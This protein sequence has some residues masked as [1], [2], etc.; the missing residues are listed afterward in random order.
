VN[1]LQRELA[2]ISERAWKAIDDEARRSL[3]HFLTG[4]SLFPFSGPRGYETNSVASGRTAGSL[5]MDGVRA[6]VLAVQP[7][8]EF[9][10]PFALSRD[11]IE[12]L[13]RDGDVDLAVVEDAARRAAAAEDRL[14]FNGLDGAGVDGCAS[15]S[16]HDPIKLADDADSYPRAVA[17]AVATLRGHGIGGPYGIALGQNDHLRVIESTE[18]GGYPVLQHLHLILDGPVVWAPIMDGAVVVSQ[19]GGGDF[20]I[21]SGIDFAVGYRAHDTDTVQLELRE[22]VT[23]RNQ[24][25][26]AAISIVH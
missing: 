9:R 2:P 21:V 16:P 8:I 15:A 12:V 4:R 1:S 24:S 6:S 26:E 3:E 17:Q 13:E 7:L 25:P 23:F 18:R 20:E 11:D 19:R 22:S 10:T 5:D 14:I